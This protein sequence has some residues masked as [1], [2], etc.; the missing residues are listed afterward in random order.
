MELPPTDDK[1]REYVYSNVYQEYSD[2][3]TGFIK[4]MIH[5]RD[6]WIKSLNKKN[7]EQ[8]INNGD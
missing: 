4:G 3:V 8:D 5:M 1:I 6:L 2:E 7:N